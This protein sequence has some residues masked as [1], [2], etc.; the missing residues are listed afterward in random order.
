MN[1][2]SWALLAALFAGVTAVLAKIGVGNIN[3]HYA[4]AIRT[5]VVLVFTWVIAFSFAPVQNFAAIS[6]KT[7]LFLGLSGIATGLSWVCYFKALQL[8]EASRVVSIDKLG[9]VFAVIFAVIFLRERLS[10]VQG[11]GLLMIVVGAL[12]MSWKP[13]S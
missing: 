7:W 6:P 1:W 11:V 10:W 9:V 8:G 2:F 4:T 5:T 12:A 3:S 13:A